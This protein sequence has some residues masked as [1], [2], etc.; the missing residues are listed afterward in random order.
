MPSFRSFTSVL[1]TGLLILGVPFV[2]AENRDYKR[3]LP[4]ENCEY[5][6]YATGLGTGCNGGFEICLSKHNEGRLPKKLEFE[7]DWQ[8]VRGLI[9]TWT[10]NTS[11][12]IG[13]IDYRG[14]KTRKA[15]IEWDPTKDRIT[16]LEM[17][18]TARGGTDGG[19]GRIRIATSAGG[20]LD[21]ANDHSDQTPDWTADLSGS[22]SLLG[23][24]GRADW[25]LDSLYFITS[26][27]KLRKQSIVEM[28][29]DPSLDQINA[30]DSTEERG[31]QVMM[32]E[33][34]RFS[35]RESGTQ[36][37]SMQKAA[38]FTTGTTITKETHDS[39]NL[40]LGFDF[41]D[42]LGFPEVFSNDM[43][44]DLDLKWK[45]SDSSKSTLD[46]PKEESAT[47]EVALSL[48]PGESATCEA[49]V[50][51]GSVEA[52][53]EGKVKVEFEDE[54]Y[55]TFDSRGHYNTTGVS[56]GTMSSCETD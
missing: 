40:D 54:T 7:G 11:T 14:D 56:R 50:F 26:N 39:F 41:I 3:G 13:S 25:A 51:T 52:K 38:N 20:F 42:P 21:L 5:G 35:N 29:L 23:I 9:V 28:T 43:S 6:D 34:K 32:V 10:D 17:W 12:E 53:W 30:R 22:G 27:S 46:D 16:Q 8:A 31:F 45:L 47:A 48:K 18:T 36:Q 33:Q 2:D 4:K 15:T 37:Y 19:I 24:H 1:A 49:W 55:F 44:K